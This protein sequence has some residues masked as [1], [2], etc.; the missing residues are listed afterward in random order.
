MVVAGLQ[1]LV[2]R[3]TIFLPPYDQRLSSDTVV[4]LHEAIGKARR[5]VCPKPA[6]SFK[7]RK[8]TPEPLAT[9]IA[10]VR[11]EVGTTSGEEHLQVCMCVCA[12]PHITMCTFKGT[13]PVNVCMC[14]SHVY[15]M[16]VSPSGW[17]RRAFERLFVPAPGHGAP[18]DQWCL[19]FVPTLNEWVKR[20]FCLFRLLSRLRHGFGR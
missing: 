4:S 10:Q 5:H 3:A 17:V 20:A 19:R 16:C 18:R 14:V 9:L 13:Y 15:H 7:T 6:F 8:Q 1:E 11:R 12:H 2:A